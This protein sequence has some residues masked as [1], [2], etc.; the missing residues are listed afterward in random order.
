MENEKIH[1]I[2][3]SFYD[4]C[5]CVLYMSPVPSIAI[6]NYNFFHHPKGPLLLLLLRRRP[7]E[8]LF[9]SHKKLIMTAKSV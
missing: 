5:V 4:V 7:N 2:F 9:I 6:I 8:L 1:Q 3:I